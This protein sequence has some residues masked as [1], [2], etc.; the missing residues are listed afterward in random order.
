MKARFAAKRLLQEDTRAVAAIELGLQDR[1]FLGNLH[2]RR[3]WGHAR[4]YVEG[5]WL[6]VQQP[7]P[8]DYVLATGEAHTFENLSKNRLHASAGAWSGKVRAWK[9]RA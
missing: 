4:D 3:D 9:K 1:I 5:M 2:A 7:T 6:I 8:D